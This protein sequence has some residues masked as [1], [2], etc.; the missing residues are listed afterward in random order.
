MNGAFQPIR[1]GT[2]EICHCFLLPIRQNA[3]QDYLSVCQTRGH[4]DHKISMTFQERNFVQP[5]HSQPRV[6]RPVYFGCNQPFQNAQDTVIR[7]FLFE[8][9]ILN[10]T[11]DQL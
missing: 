8:A 7:N 11:I 1:N 5:K 4:N 3:Q 9:H 10:R 2:Q 6:L